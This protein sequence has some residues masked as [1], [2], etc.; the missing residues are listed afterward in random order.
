MTRTL[1]L[2]LLLT[3][4]SACTGFTS[5]LGGTTP[6][7]GSV[8]PNSTVQLLPNL[9]IPLEKLVYWGAYAGVA[10]MILDPLAPNWEIEEAPFP[11]NHFHLSL[12]MKRY[13]AGGAGEARVVFK[14]RARELMR[15]GGFDAYEVMEYSEGLESSVLGSQ[16]VSEGVIHLTHKNVQG[17]SAPPAPS[18]PDNARNPLS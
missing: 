3:S 18:T 5:R 10:Y 15:V 16:R 12:K 6:R 14:Q 7:T 1:A 11:D 9:A 13:Y 4:L 8:V 17:S 2:I